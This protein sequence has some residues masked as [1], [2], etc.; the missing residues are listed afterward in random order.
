MKKQILIIDDDRRLNQLLTAYLSDFGFQVT[1]AVHPEDGLRLLRDNPPD[2]VVLDVMLPD[3]NGF[4]VCREIRSFSTVPVIML[5]ARGEVM[6][7]VVGL[8]LGADD[9][10]AKPFDPRELAA[11]IQAVLRRTG[12]TGALQ[13]A[14][15]GRLIV[16]FAKRTAFLD[17]RNVELTTNEFTVLRLLVQNPGR[18]L[19]RDQI[20]QELRGMDSDAFNRSVD[21]TVSRLRQRLGDDPGHPQYIRTVRGTGYVFIAGDQDEAG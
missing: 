1:G 12:E 10:L 3:K 18:V 6:D 5:T 4:E 15:F 20:L 13:R 2:L 19:D 17:G 7:R 9:Y 16:D 8:E 14:C 11:R 21:I